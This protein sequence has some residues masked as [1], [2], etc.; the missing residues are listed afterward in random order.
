LHYKLRPHHRGP[1]LCFN[2]FNNYLHKCYR[3][4]T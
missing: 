2:F 3:P 4:H 1:G